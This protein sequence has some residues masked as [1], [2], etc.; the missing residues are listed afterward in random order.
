MF[1]KNLTLPNKKPRTCL[2][3]NTIDAFNLVQLWFVNST[4]VMVLP[5]KSYISLAL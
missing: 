2:R 4:F 3:L 1:H 5:S